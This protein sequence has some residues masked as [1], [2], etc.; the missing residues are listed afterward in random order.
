MNH[1][2][3]S[4]ADNLQNVRQDIKKAEQAAGREPDVVKLLAVSKK[5]SPEKLVQAIEAGQRCFGENYVSEAVEKQDALSRILPEADFDALEWHYIGPVQSNKTRLIAERFDWVHSLDRLK[6]AK[7]LSDQRPEAAGALNICIQVNIDD[8]E[9]KSGLGL[10]QVDILAEHIVTLESLRLRG[11][12]AIPKAAQAP[13]QS[14]R[15]F[16]TLAEAFR[17]LQQ[18]YASVDT[19]SM[20]MSG[21]FEQAILQ[22]ST[23]VRVGTRLFG[24]R[25]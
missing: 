1:P 19:L 15:A 11:L 12:M 25:A 3:F 14:A 16:A 9:S 18:R 5:Q 2:M 23:M 24:A 7:R 6:I 4:I 17:R 10:D 21:D 20:G 8:E 13:E 22:G